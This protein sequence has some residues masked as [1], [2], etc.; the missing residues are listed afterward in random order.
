MARQFSGSGLRLMLLYH[1]PEIERLRAT[2]PVNFDI[3]GA[4]LDVAN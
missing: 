3:P 1:S 4:Q 2:L